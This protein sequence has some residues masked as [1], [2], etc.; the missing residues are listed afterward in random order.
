M[1][2]IAHTL[3]AA[4]LGQTGLKKLSPLGMATLLLAANLP[5][6]DAVFMLFG[7]DSALYHRRGWTHGILALALLPL[8]L[9][10]LVIAYDRLIRLRLHPDK[11]PVN[12]KFALLLSLIGMLSHQFLD[13]LNTYGV[14]LM[15]PFSQKWFYG[16]ILFIIDPW[17]WLLMAASVVLAYSRH[18]V[19]KVLWM[20][21]GATT[22]M[23]ILTS[24]LVPTLAKILWLTGIFLI[25]GLRFYRIDG[26]KN[27]KLAYSWLFLLCCY[28]GFT[29]LGNNY[30]RRQILQNDFAG[31]ATTVSDVMIGPLPANPFQKFL[32]VA[33]D[34]HYHAYTF[35][36]WGQ[37]RMEKAYEAVPIQAPDEIVR[38]A[39]ASPELKGFSQWMRFPF[40]TVEPQD[41][42]FL[43]SI[44]DLRYVYPH[45]PPGPGIGFAKVFVKRS[46]L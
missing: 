36:F 11:C 26:M 2:P 14:R 12:V 6:I 37:P 4:T 10:T 34:T 1:D 38:A 41:G 16:D 22:T 19:G 28:L 21:L 44:R 24:A 32:I 20:L 5:D 9:V 18:Q 15:M 45:G 17:M 39:L 25:M 46:E 40:Y 43:V 23:L 30:V 42:G 13:W 27:Q 31:S 29:G 33:T 8:M 3:T 7:A 35:R